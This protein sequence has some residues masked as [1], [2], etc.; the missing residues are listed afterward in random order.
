MIVKLKE[1]QQWF[2]KQKIFSFASTSVL[3]VYDADLQDCG[4]NH[5]ISSSNQCRVKM[6][7]F[8]HVYEADDYDTNYQQGIASTIHHLE[9]CL[10]TVKL[11]KE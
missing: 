2:L 5:K 11:Q 4:L 6:I 3:I 9:R 10:S 8:S 7:D 1:I